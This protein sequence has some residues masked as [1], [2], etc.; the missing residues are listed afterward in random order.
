METHRG[1][2]ID[3]VATAFCL[4]TLCCWSMGPLFIKYLAGFVDSWTQNLLRYST[5]CLF[6]LPF[7]IVS[8][9]KGKVERH[10]WR[11]ALMPSAANLVM[12]SF[13]AASFYYIDPA[14]MNLLIKSSVIWIAAF[15]IIFFRDERPLLKSGRFWMGLFLCV[16][17]VAGVLVFK[18]GFA[19]K[20]AATG[21]ILALSAAF[22][23]SIYTVLVRT[24]FKRVDSRLGFAVVSMYTMVGL[25]IVASIFGNVSDCLQ[26]GL[27]QWLCVLISGLLAI[28]LSHVL[29][30][31]TIKRIGAT[32]PS[33]VLLA[34]PFTVLAA[35]SVLFGERLSGPQIM[36][37]L[38][39]LAGAALAIW[40]QQH[41]GT[42][43]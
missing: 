10:I 31:S 42:S 4:G 13:W 17:G 22:M 9:N 36:F 15:S 34:T 1:R 8:L 30:Y 43:E 21:I 41:L 37:G 25:G 6:W 40:T 35:S 27:W 3:F 33:L 19:S 29:Y 26:M 12:Q 7:L 28:A 39:L 20:K 16:I 18:E 23:W 24:A 11:L 2:K 32:I 5:A 38:I 14:F